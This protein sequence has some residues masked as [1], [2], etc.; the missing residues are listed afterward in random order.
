MQ[1]LTQKFWRSLVSVI[2]I[3]PELNT[4]FECTHFST[5]VIRFL[6]LWNANVNFCI[7]VCLSSLI[8]ADVSWRF[9]SHIAA[10]KAE[11]YIYKYLL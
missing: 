3:S 7:S 4:D 6:L 1:I 11:N 2:K 10:T 8:P 9:M 5:R